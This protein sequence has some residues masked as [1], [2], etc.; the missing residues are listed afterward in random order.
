[1]GSQEFVEGSWDGRGGDRGGACGGE[2]GRGTQEATWVETE[3]PRSECGPGAAVQERGRHRA[4]GAH[5]QAH[6]LRW[7]H[8]RRSK[9]DNLHTL[10][11]NNN[12]YSL[13]AFGV[14]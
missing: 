2:R 7:T 6:H 10:Q 3:E 4:P 11:Y 9:A 14:Y 12:E 1:M 8:V 5:H 13:S